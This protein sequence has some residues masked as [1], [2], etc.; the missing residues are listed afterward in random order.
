LFN[1]AQLSK[2]YRTGAKSLR[3]A[4]V[5]DAAVNVAFSASVTARSNHGRAAANSPV[6][7]RQ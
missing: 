2:A 3:E 6:L 5:I 7:D 4:L 1:Q